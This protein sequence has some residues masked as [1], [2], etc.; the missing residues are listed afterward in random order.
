LLGLLT[1]PQRKFLF[2]LNGVPTALLNVLQARSK[3]A[4]N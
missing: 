1:T 3:Q 4:A 2:V